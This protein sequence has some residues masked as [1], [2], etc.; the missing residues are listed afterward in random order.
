MILKY[1][2]LS[3]GSAEHFN[4]SFQYESDSVLKPENS[5]GVRRA[6]PASPVGEQLATQPDNSGGVRGA[7]PPPPA[8]PVGEQLAT[9]P[10]NSGGPWGQSPPASPVGEQLATQ[11]FARGAHYPFA[12]ASRK[13]SPELRTFGKNCRGASTRIMRVTLLHL[14]FAFL[15]FL[16]FLVLKCVISDTESDAVPYVACEMLVRFVVCNGL[17]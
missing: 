7:E 4:V 15:A 10:D 13:A 14:Q 3:T 9:Q 16:Y 6:P 1:W 2:G 8:S 5:G 12:R 11:P 17:E